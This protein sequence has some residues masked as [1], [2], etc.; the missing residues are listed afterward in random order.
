MHIPSSM[1]NILEGTN[2]SVVFFAAIPANYGVTGSALT[3]DRFEQVDRLQQVAIGT[4]INSIIFTV[5]LRNITASASVEYAIFKIE[6]SNQV[7]DTD[8]ISLPN[9]A[10]I[11]TEGLQSAMRRFQPGR[12]I[13]FGVVGVAAEQPR[14]LSLKANYKKF[15]M[16]KVRTGDYYGIIIFSRGTS[17]VIDFQA[18]YNALT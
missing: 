9:D 4:E 15:K 6:R 17:S 2:T 7:P 14:V 8:N 16:S 5:T 10:S 12:I 18:R 3:S 11:T 1:A 13:K